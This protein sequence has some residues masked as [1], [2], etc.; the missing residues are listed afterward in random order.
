[1]RKKIGTTLN[2]IPVVKT[3]FTQSYT[4]TPRIRTTIEYDLEGTKDGNH[5]GHIIMQKGKQTILW[6]ESNWHQNFITSGGA[7]QSKIG[8]PQPNLLRTSSQGKKKQKQ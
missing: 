5:R 3:L 4:I 7:I 8:S 1:M 2:G 6:S